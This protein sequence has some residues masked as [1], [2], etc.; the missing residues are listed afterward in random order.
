M[1]NDSEYGFPL[2]LY[3]RDSARA[4]NVAQRLHTDLPYQWPNGA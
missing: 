1:A 4:W 2:R 3:S